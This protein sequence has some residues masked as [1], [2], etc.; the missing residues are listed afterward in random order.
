MIFSLEATLRSSAVPSGHRDEQRCAN[1]NPGERGQ[2][3]H[4]IRWLRLGDRN[5]TSASPSFRS[6]MPTRATLSS[7]PTSSPLRHCTFSS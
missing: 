1:R 2:P 7:A 6:D 4:T 3:R 5:R